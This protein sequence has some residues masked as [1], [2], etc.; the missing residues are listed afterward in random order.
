M[1]AGRG[2]GEKREK[3]QNKEN[4][5]FQK[6]GVAVCAAGIREHAVAVLNSLKRQCFKIVV[7]ALRNSFNAFWPRCLQNAATTRVEREKSGGTSFRYIVLRKAELAR[8]Q[9]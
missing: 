5:R 7:R 6:L 2:R 1:D 3:K 8:T 4:S 9:L